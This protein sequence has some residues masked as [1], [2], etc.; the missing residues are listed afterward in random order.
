[1]GFMYQEVTEEQKAAFASKA[2]LIT[3]GCFP[4][5]TRRRV[6]LHV[7]QKFMGNRTTHCF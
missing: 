2:V 6:S 3:G 4:P 5:P 7:V 1:M